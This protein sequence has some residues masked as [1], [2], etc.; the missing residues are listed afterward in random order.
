MTLL[1]RKL[2][3][4]RDEGTVLAAGEFDILL[5]GDLNASK[6]DAHREGFFNDLNT[7]DWGVLAGATYPGTR[8]AGVPLIPK[9]QID[10]LIVTRRTTTK[11][12]LL[13]EEVAGSEATV[14]QELA[15]SQWDS[16]RRTFSDHFP[17]TTCV[18]VMEDND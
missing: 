10:Y 17:V 13:G 12:G 15:N 5:G 11:A 7:G 6:Y 16:F 4:V 18:G 14:H 3:E 8:L 2:E 1:I 9:S